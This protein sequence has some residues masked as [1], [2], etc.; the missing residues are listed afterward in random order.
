MTLQQIKYFL[1]LAKELHYWRTSSEMNI[2]QSALSRQIQSLEAELEI[3]LFKR[4]KRKV[5]LTTAGKFLQEQWTPLVVQM[6]ALN[7]YAKKIQ[8]G[9][10]GSLVINHPGSISYKLLPD[11]VSKI[12]GAFPGV[13]TELIQ[14]KHDQEEHFLRTFKIDLCFSRYVHNSDFLA[15]KLFQLDHYAFA[16]PEGHAIKDEN[17]LNEDI[18]RAER[19]IL[20]TLGAGHSYTA[21]ISKVFEHYQISPD[22]YHESDFGSTVLA[23]V[24]RGL[25]VS[26]V[27]FSIAEPGFTGVRFIK[28]P[29]EVPLY[30]YWRKDETSPLV[31]NVLDL[32]L[33]EEI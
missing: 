15:S 26:V 12:S 2:T 21:Q 13:K 20:P 19:F 18:L 8:L 27:P 16:L 9:T 6:D 1:A 11:L 5:E 14:L 23:L 25:G 24:S 29:F 17:A 32:I 31:R 22:V 28:T 7:T 33:Q 30:L 10:R 3:K 4:T